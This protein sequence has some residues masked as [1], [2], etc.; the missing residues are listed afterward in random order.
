MRSPAS[1]ARRPS[2]VVLT[3]SCMSQAQWALVKRDTKGQTTRH[4]VQ[5]GASTQA[6]AAAALAQL[7]HASAAHLCH[8]ALHLCRQ[9]PIVCSTHR[10]LQHHSVIAAQG[11]QQMGAA[12]STTAA[13]A[14]AGAGR[15]QH[16]L[17]TRQPVEEGVP[18]LRLHHAPPPILSQQVL[19]GRAGQAGQAGGPA[20]GWQRG[21]QAGKHSW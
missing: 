5:Q 18:A 9:Q 2:R 16:P 1:P 15:A 7:A 19:Q 10:G 11:V 6:R 21:R 12:T 4:A 20:G 14:K 13:A 8:P 17:L 3:P